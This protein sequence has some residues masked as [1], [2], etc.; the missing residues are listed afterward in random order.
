MKIEGN[1]TLQAQA[2]HQLQQQRLQKNTAV[3]RNSQDEAPATIAKGNSGRQ[4]QD[5]S[6]QA[7]GALR[8]MQ[9]GHF[10]GVADLRLRINFA[11]QLQEPPPLGEASSKGAAYNKFLEIYQQLSDIGTARGEESTPETGIEIAV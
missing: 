5:S 4:A 10:K 1:S 2:M 3:G 11:D 9:E 6:G 8:L 7:Q